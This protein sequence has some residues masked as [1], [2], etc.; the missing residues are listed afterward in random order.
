MSKGQTSAPTTSCADKQNSSTHPSKPFTFPHTDLGP[1]Y[2]QLKGA[3]G[4]LIVAAG[5]FIVILGMAMLVVAGLG[6]KTGRTT[7]NVMGKI[8][9]AGKPAR[10]VSS[11]V[12]GS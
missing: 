1:T 10:A 3:Q 4:A 8:P 5:G 12:T 11:R 2:C 9:V 6:S 7:L